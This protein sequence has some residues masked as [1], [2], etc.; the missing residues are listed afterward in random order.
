MIRVGIR[1]TGTGPN[2][3]REIRISVDPAG[4][5]GRPSITGEI[6]T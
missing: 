5:Q 6:H 4:R 1:D 3:T 2:M